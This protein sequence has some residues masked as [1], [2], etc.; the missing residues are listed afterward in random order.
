MSTSGEEGMV[1]IHVSNAENLCAQYNQETLDRIQSTIALQELRAKGIWQGI[2]L[3]RRMARN[4]VLLDAGET[5]DPAFG[6]LLLIV[7]LLA[8]IGTRT[9]VS[10]CDATGYTKQS[11]RSEMYRALGLICAISLRNMLS[12]C[13]ASIILIYLDKRVPTRRTQTTD[14]PVLYIGPLTWSGPPVGGAVAHIC[15]IVNAFCRMGIPVVYPSSWH[16]ESID[17]HADVRDIRLS[18]EISLPTEAALYHVQLSSFISLLKIGREKK[19]RYIYARSTLGGFSTV[20]LARVLGVPLV[21]EYNGS[22]AWISRNWGHSLRFGWL[23]DLAE[24]VCLKHADLIFTI[25]QHLANELREKGCNEERIT[26]LPNGV[27]YWRFGPDVVDASNGREIREA[28]GI[29]K[30]AAIIG[31]IGTFGQ[32]HGTDVL[33]HAIEKVAARRPSLVGEG[34]LHFLVAGDGKHRERFL[35]II[36]DAGLSNMV[37]APGTISQSYGPQLL[38]SCDI[39]VAPHVENTDGTPFFGS[40]IKLFEYLASARPIVASNLHQLGDVLCDSPEWPEIG[41]AEDKEF[42]T[43][44]GILVPPGDPDALAQALIYFVENTTATKNAGQFARMIATERHGWDRH[45][46]RISDHFPN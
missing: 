24:I 10:L 3:L 21:L 46:K 44:P 20:L 40:P 15:G 34:K 7:A 32:W 25:S 2:K 14:G 19:P 5:I 4:G 33:A 1:F 16:P 13:V 9:Q 29:P 41:T 27:E 28:Y 37:S 8:V 36:N 43:A 30:D 17:Q 38:A 11:S 6:Q 22:E 39:L 26:W 23:A 18:T 12:T 31:Y 35:E 45:V 42:K